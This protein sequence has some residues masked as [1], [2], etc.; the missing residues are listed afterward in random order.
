[1]LR[2]GRFNQHVR[3]GCLLVEVGNNR[4]T[5]GEALASMPYLAD[6]LDEA[7]SALRSD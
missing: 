5:L 2:A 3:V 7:L 1:M 6:A 4:N